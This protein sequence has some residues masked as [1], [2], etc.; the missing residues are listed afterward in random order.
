MAKVKT[1]ELGETKRC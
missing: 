1:V